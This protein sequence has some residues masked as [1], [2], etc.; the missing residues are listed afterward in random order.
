MASP[1]AEARF[2]STQSSRARRGHPVAEWGTL[3]ESRG[4]SSRRR[5][6]YMRWSRPTLSW[7][8]ESGSHA[9]WRSGDRGDLHRADGRAPGWRPVVGEDTDDDRVGPRGAA[10]EQAS[11]SLPARGSRR[12]VGRAPRSCVRDVGVRGRVRRAFVRSASSRSSFQTWWSCG[13][14]CLGGRPRSA[15]KRYRSAIAVAASSAR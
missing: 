2:P 8:L 13:T 5:R 14:E 9:P 10:G 12:C 1:C 7:P 11:P 3:A 15:R 4:G 6:G